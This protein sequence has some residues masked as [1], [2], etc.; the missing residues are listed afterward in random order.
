MTKELT[1]LRKLW[2]Q[3]VSPFVDRLQT[4]RPPQSESRIWWRPTADFP[5][6]PLHPAGPYRK[7]Q[8][9]LPHLYISSTMESVRDVPFDQR[10]LYIYLGA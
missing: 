10:I 6:L 3:I 2:D 4:T 5:A 9:N 8:Q 7:G 1:F